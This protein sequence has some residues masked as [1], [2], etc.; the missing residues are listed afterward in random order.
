MSDKKIRLKVITP[1][2][3]LVDEDVDEIYS[4][5]VDGEFGILPGHS[6][7][8]TALDTCITKYIKD[9]K[10]EYISTI[11]GIFQVDKDEAIIL[12]DKA[13]LG[14]EIDITRANIA[15]ERAEARL[16]SGKREVDTDR[17]QAALARAI[18]R[19]QASGKSRNL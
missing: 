1:I 6:G 13:E 15:K 17:A 4:K 18:V 19:L 8:I 11:G 14:E 3:V 2:K 5:A 7:F 12:T 16:R 10:Q 9:S